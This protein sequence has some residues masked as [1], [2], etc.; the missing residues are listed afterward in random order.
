M[1]D[2]LQGRKCLLERRVYTINLGETLLGGELMENVQ[3]I[4]AF[5]KIIKPL[6][7]ASLKAGI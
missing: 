5:L 7:K 1:T 4:K 3:L 2:D 6:E